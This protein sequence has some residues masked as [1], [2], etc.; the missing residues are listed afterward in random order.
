[1]LGKHI[2]KLHGVGAKSCSLCGHGYAGSGAE[3]RLR[4]HMKKH[5]WSPNCKQCEEKVGDK[6][7]LSLHIE[8]EHTAEPCA[9][10]TEVSENK[11]GLVSHMQAVHSLVAHMCGCEG[12][13]WGSADIVALEDHW[14]QSHMNI[15]FSCGRC[16]EGYFTWVKLSRHMENN[17]GGPATTCPHCAKSFP[18]DGDL[19]NH[20]EGVHMMGG[21]ACAPCQLWFDNADWLS[22]HFRTE[23]LVTQ[24][25]CEGCGEKDSDGE[26]LW[27]HMKEKHG[28]PE[29]EVWQDQRSEAG[30][31]STSSASLEP[32]AQSTS[33]ESRKQVQNGCNLCDFI[34]HAERPKDQRVNVRRHLQR[35][36]P[37][38]A[39]AKPSVLLGAQEAKV[40][41]E[42]ED[43]AGDAV[44]TLQRF[45]PGAA[46]AKPSVLL[47]AKEAKVVEEG[48][49]EA[50]VAVC[51]TCGKSFTKYTS[52]ER[53]HENTHRAERL[54]KTPPR[55]REGGNESMKAK[56]GASIQVKEGGV[57]SKKVNEEAGSGHTTVDQV[58]E[59]GNES[60]TAQEDAT[61]HTTNSLWLEC[62][63]DVAGN[64]FYKNPYTGAIS[65]DRPVGAGTEVVSEA[66][67]GR[68]R[69]T[70][71]KRKVGKAEVASRKRVRR[72]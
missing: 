22:E 24:Y 26:V 35:F 66:E 50:G 21:Y 62:C 44:C 29:A 61:G 46:A 4:V 63:P 23:H 19:Q 5:G 20:L 51:K 72:G 52:L 28:R 69:A 25:S 14:K 11:A 43:E 6:E 42:G 68:R 15:G 57:L 27:Q 36:H 9:F 16:K 38:A 8:E 60:M 64:T 2:E 47:G 53:H 65:R 67:F 58:K 7:A 40:V 17:H 59:G 31:L 39:A 10:C 3:I 49:D 34:S 70:A 54:Q 33:S 71:D 45:H 55:A 32:D 13:K 48:E 18:V 56:E 41:E 30:A 1:M 12:C 37:G